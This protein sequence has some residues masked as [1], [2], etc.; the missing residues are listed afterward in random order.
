MFRTLGRPFQWWAH[1]NNSVFALVC[2]RSEHSIPRYLNPINYYIPYFVPHT[3]I[4]LILLCLQAGQLFGWEAIIS[5]I[6]VS[7][8]Y[9]VA[10]GSPSFGRVLH[11]INPSSFLRLGAMY[12]C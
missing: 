4:S 10:I 3:S 5:F 8:V 7:V 12:L 6:L 11:V 1:P 9:A 2:D